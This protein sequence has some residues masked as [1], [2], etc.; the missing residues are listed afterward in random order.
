MTSETIES[1]T[2]AEA[3]RQKIK[4]K[5]AKKAKA[6]K[7]SGHTKK[8]AGKPKADRAKKKAE[9]KKKKSEVSVK[10]FGAYLDEK[11]KALGK[12]SAM[13]LDVFGMKQAQ[14]TIASS[15]RIGQLYADFVGQLY[16]AEIPKDLKV[17]DEWGN[18]PQEIF[19]DALVAAERARHQC[20][21]QLHH[22]L[23]RLC[24]PLLPQS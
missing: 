9:V 14:W 22:R 6:A 8:A 19:C 4:R 10:K 21:P 2:P 5:P 17:Q 1:N 7:K 12:A 3:E 18:R 11:A 23:Q 16:T 13:Y 15:A 20:V 24:D